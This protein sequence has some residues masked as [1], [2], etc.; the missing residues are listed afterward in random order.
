MGGSG[1]PNICVLPTIKL[2]SG[3]TLVKAIDIESLLVVEA[4]PELVA[5]HLDCSWHGCLQLHET[6][7]KDRQLG[8][9]LSGDC[10]TDRS[11]LGLNLGRGASDL[12]PL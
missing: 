6:T 3:H 4:L 11:A 12:H 1:I 9:L 7:V 2:I 10:V 5:S 8:Y